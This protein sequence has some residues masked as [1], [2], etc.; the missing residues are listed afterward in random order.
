MTSQVQ[1]R[2]AL[3]SVFS[4]DRIDT[5]A[6]ILNE[7]NIKIISTGGTSDF[8]RKLGIDV[9]PVESITSYP[10]IL[11]GRVKTLHPKIF[12]GILYRR[13]HD[14]DKTE[15]NQ[16]EIPPVDLVIVDLY[17][18]EKTVE[19]TTDEVEIIE[20][21]D[22]G[23]ISLIRAAAKNFK[24]VLIVPS[25]EQYDELIALLRAKSGF[26]DINDRKYF[27]S[28]A[29][30]VTSHYDTRIFGY[31]NKERQIQVFKQSINKPNALRYGENPH[32]LGIFYGNLDDVLEQLHGKAISYNN[33]VDIDAAISL[34]SEFTS[35][36]TFVVIKH[37]NA[38]GVASRAGL[39]EAW[40][41]ALAC[42]PVSAFGGVITANRPIDYGTATELNK[43]FFEILLAEDFENDALKLL[44]SKKNRIILRKKPFHL[45]GFQFKS[46]LN[47]VLE[48]EKDLKTETG[49]ELKQ[50][51]KKAPLASEISDLLYANIIVKHQKSNTIVL[52]KNKQ[53]I[54][55]GI[56]QTSR[57][58]ALKQAIIKAKEFGFDLKGAVLASDAFFPF[59]DCVEIAHQEEIGT[60]IQPGGSIR[61]ADSIN[62]CDEH[63]MSMV[64]TGIRHF[65]H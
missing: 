5:I 26:T 36:P 11:G 32:Q 54:G 35:E 16:Y 2:S 6:K 46:I 4:K 34:V 25:S 19:Q 9:T 13:D 18:F 28:Q 62:F 57:V 41:D 58:D 15:L 40:T 10:S 43:L 63:D 33:I 48:Q 44:K 49:S 53:L 47:G 51:T 1:I 31:F 27:A 23:G 12:G 24:D 20:K 64:F 14:Q 42:D 17:P 60:V 61:D 21:I 22:I 37:T 38:C 8:I 7:L 50:V 39:K 65:K 52:V 56:G 55:S 45:S 30:N 3:I 59:A 29:F